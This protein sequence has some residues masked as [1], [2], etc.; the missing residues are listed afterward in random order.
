MKPLNLNS[1]PMVP[2]LRWT[3]GLLK[4]LETILPERIQPLLLEQKG[5][6]SPAPTFPVG[7]SWVSGSWGQKQGEQW[8]E[9]RLLVQNSAHEHAWPLTALPN[10]VHGP[11]EADVEQEKPL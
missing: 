7:S 9:K 2:I 4:Y 5:K 1:L 8:A 6:I 10:I 11:K 3:P